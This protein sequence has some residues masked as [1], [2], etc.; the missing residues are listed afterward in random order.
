MFGSD[1]ANLGFGNNQSKIAVKDCQITRKT[2]YLG[3]KLDNIIENI[4]PVV[5][6][7]GIILLKDGREGDFYGKTKNI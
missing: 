6:P 1:Y 3:D 5:R 7:I 4:A 2:F